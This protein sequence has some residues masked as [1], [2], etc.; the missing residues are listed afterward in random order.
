VT[1]PPSSGWW[2]RTGLIAAVS[3]SGVVGEVV[4]GSSKLVH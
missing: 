2:W 1:S 3:R 4:M